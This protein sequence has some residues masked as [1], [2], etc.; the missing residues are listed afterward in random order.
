MVTILNKRSLCCVC[1][2]IVKV[3]GLCL[4]KNT[5][6]IGTESGSGVCVL[7]TVDLV[8][9]YMFVCIYFVVKYISQN[10]PF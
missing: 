7:V 6:N 2:G 3:T 9:K 1:S 8:L 10:L 5:N 4:D